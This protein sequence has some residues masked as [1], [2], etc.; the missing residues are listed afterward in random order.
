MNGRALTKVVDVS[1]R[2]AR[3]NRDEMA[4]WLAAEV[5]LADPV[6]LEDD[7]LAERLL[8][9]QDRLEAVARLRYGMPGEPDANDLSA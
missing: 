5:L 9:L 4:R 8:A 1:F 3:E 6:A 7:E 2:N